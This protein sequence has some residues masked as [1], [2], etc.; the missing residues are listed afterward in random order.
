MAKVTKVHEVLKHP[1]GRIE[2]R[3]NTGQP[4]L[5][6]AWQ[7]QSF[8]YDNE[9]ALADAMA[10][11]EE[12][13]SGET[14]ALMCVAQGW[15]KVDPSMRDAKSFKSTEVQLDLQGAQTAVKVR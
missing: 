3:H 11:A 10:Q 13:V 7:G 12:S 2:I 1:D 8:I 15:T 9:Q 5:P 6:A 4:P 14:L